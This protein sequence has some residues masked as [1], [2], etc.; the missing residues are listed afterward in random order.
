MKMSD[1]I[2][3]LRHAELDPRDAAI[4]WRFTNAYRPHDCVQTWRELREDY[5]PIEEESLMDI[6]IDQYEAETECLTPGSNTL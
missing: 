1:T 4:L 6:I 5:D 3:Q 2:Y